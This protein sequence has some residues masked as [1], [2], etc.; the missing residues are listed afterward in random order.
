M[1]LVLAAIVMLASVTPAIAADVYVSDPPHTQAFFETGHLGISWV[2]GRFKDVDAKIVVDR[3]SKQGT[4]EAVIKTPTLDTG[5]EARDK[6]VRSADYLDVEQFPTMI[7]KSNKLKF[8]GDR[9][10]AAEGD[11]TLMGVT[12]PVTLDIPYFQCVQHPANK[13]EVCGAD[14]RTTIKRSEF[15]A[16]RGASTPMADEVKISIQIE[17]YKQ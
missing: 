8:D 13:R 4:I 3:A 5:F 7:F 12:R 9:L 17:A 14:A 1:K 10:V 2:R 16:K 15:G 6:H 11:L